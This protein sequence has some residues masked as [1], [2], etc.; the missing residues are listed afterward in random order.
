M[1]R[2]STIDRAKELHKLSSKL[3]PEFHPVI[4]HSQQSTRDRRRNLAALRRFESRIIVCVDMLGKASIF[5]SSRSRG[6]TIPTRASPS[7][8]SS[9]AAL[10]DRIQHSVTRP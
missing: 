7:P 6:S 10:P 8:S 2:C 1:A 3:F 9:L 5:P 4:V